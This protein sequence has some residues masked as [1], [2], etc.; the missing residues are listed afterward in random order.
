[1]SG[2]QFCEVNGEWIVDELAV[3]DDVVYSKEDVYGKT[4]YLWQ[5]TINDDALWVMGPDRTADTFWAYRRGSDLFDSCDSDDDE[6]ALWYYSDGNQWSTHSV[7]PVVS[8]STDTDVTYT[9]PIALRISLSSGM[10]WSLCFDGT[11]CPMFDA[12]ADPTTD[13]TADPTTDP[14]ENPTTGIGELFFSV[15]VQSDG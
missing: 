13:P 4:A 10:S 3:G 1:M 11:L 15:F 7:E 12:T 8:N 9:E 14:T 5:L 6:C 2:F